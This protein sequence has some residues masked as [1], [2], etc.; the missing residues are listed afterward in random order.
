MKSKVY[1]LTGD[2][3]TTSLVGGQRVAKDDIRVEAYGTVDELNAHLGMLAHAL[4][5]QNAEVEQLLFKIQNKLFNLGAY[6]A[7]EQ[8][9][10]EAPVYGLDDSDVKAVEAMIDS[11]DEQLPPMRGFILPGGTRASVCCDLCRTITRR[12][13]RRVVTLASR[14]P[15]NPLAQ[16]Y[17]NRLSDFFFI[18]AR[19]CNV[20][21]GVD[22]VLWDRSC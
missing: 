2:K 21:A 6:L 15:L 11:L 5:G 22:E 16:R 20:T 4:K 8:S 19:H 1:T 9:N 18:L 10:V 13:E 14:Q 17:L 12:A 7:T 3:G